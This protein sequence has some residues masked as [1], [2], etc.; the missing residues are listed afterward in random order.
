M[1]SFGSQRPVELS[2]LVACIVV[3]QSTLDLFHV[4]DLMHFNSWLV[5][6]FIKTRFFVTIELS[7]E[8]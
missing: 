1:V 5:D 7:V 2:V 6:N 3:D 4:N 8:I